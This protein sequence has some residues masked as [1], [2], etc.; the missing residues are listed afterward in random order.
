MKIQLSKINLS[1]V[2]K[3]MKNL[4]LIC[5]L[6]VIS[7]T[8][9]AESITAN[10]FSFELFTT[11]AHLDVKAELTLQ[12][13]YEK[14]VISDSS[15]Y[16]YVFNYIPLERKVTKEGDRYHVVFSLKQTKK[17]EV[18]G[19]FK[20]TKECSGRV[21]ITFE[22]KKYSIG[23]ANRFD[24]P[25]SFLYLGKYRFER[26]DTKL[27]LSQLRA[28]IEQKI[29]ELRYQAYSSQVNVSLYADEVKMEGKGV[30]KDDATN[31]PY[32]LNYRP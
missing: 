29:F 8:A 24:K 4:I 2:A 25:I 21:D 18:T 16:E 32:P 5:T 27:N 31:M 11:Q 26:G 9:Q 14:W 6:F 30:A 13:R 10:P 7:L 12:C 28:D 15:Q 22:D 1:V 17:T 19:A 3:G 20:P 23:W